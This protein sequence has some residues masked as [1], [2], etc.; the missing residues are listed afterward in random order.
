MNFYLLILVILITIIAFIFTNSLT[1]LQKI[2]VVNRTI[3]PT[4][5]AVFYGHKT[6]FFQAGM[7]DK[8]CM[9]T[10]YANTL[11]PNPTDFTNDYRA[12]NITAN[13]LIIQTTDRSFLAATVRSNK[14]LPTKH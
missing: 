9:A 13:S 6:Q 12:I 4:N 8:N 5:P 11:A 10:I 3:S 7:L 1:Y 2:S 14:F